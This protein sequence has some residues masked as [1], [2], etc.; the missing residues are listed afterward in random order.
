MGRMMSQIAHRQLHELRDRL[1]QPTL[2]RNRR[3]TKTSCSA[4]VSLGDCVQ[5]LAEIHTNVYASIERLLAIDCPIRGKR[6]AARVQRD[7][8]RCD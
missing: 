7:I 5:S 8:G 4:G 2:L 3:P 1:T 6:L